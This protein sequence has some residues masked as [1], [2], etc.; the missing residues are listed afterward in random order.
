M[1]VTAAL[2]SLSNQTTHAAR[3]EAAQARKE[4]K[5]KERKEKIMAEEDPEKQKRLEVNAYNDMFQLP[6]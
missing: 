1:I 6:Y 4:E 3:V 5:I 2:N